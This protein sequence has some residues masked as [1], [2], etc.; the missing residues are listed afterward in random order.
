MKKLLLAFVSCFLFLASFSFAAEFIAGE[1]VSVPGGKNDFYAGWTTVTITDAIDGDLRLATSV[2]TI[3]KSVSQDVMVG[4]NIVLVNAPIGDDLRA[5][6]NQVTVNASVKWDLIIFANTIIIWKDVVIGWDVSLFG[7]KIILEGTVNGKAKLYG[8]HITL[9]GMIGKEVDLRGDRVSV[10][11]GAKIGWMLN[12]ALSA[13]DPELEKIAS[14]AVFDA[15]YSSNG[16]GKEEGFM[17]DGGIFAGIIAALIAFKFLSLLLV[18]LIA[19]VIFKRWYVRAG[20][21][22]MARPW[23]S[24]GLGVMQVVLLPIIAL[25]LGLTGVLAVVGWLAF[26][27]WLFLLLFWKLRLLWFLRDGSTKN[28]IRQNN[29][30]KISCLLLLCHLYVVWLRVLMDF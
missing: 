1:T 29:D 14:G 24:L 12:Y 22:V 8:G 26:A 13:Q 15:K 9:N 16:E 4:G 7:E 25:I 18:S 3:D 20:E 11:S 6:G 5:G 19:W 23:E 10:G 21:L 30:G 28:I 27:V 2:A 17:K